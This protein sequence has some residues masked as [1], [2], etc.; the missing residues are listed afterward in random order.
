M[1][2]QQELVVQGEGRTVEDAVK[3]ALKKLGLTREDVKVTVVQEGSKGVLGMGSRLARV[4][5]APL[6]LGQTADQPVVNEEQP[7]EPGQAKTTPAPTDVT[8]KIEH[9]LKLMKM[10]V[11]VTAGS[12]PDGMMFELAGPDSAILIGR[13]GKTL[14]ALEQVIYRLVN[15]GSMERQRVSVDIEKYHERRKEK[16]VKIAISTAGTVTE[17][18][19]EITLDPMNPRDR[20]DVHM[21]LADRSDVKTVS[22]GEG[23]ARCVVVI[24][25]NEKTGKR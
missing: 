2:E 6:P 8:G 16:L 18:G 1:E 20:R 5:V 22:R 24:P 17:N 7:R 9:M 21:A 19:R 3:A 15:K 4:K 23:E 10:D 25:G 13:Q 14:E 12:R 11:T